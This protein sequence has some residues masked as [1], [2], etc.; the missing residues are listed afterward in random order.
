M[1][2]RPTTVAA[3]SRG[4]LAARREALQILL[5]V[6]RDRAY[7]DVLLGRRLDGFA[8]ADRRLITQLVLGTLAWRGRLDFELSRHAT[9]PLDRLAPEVL[10]A[11]RMGLFQIRIL[12]RIPGHAA[13]DTAVG[14]TRQLAGRRSAGLVNAVLRKA[15]RCPV[16]LPPRATDQIAYLAIAYSHPRWL[17]EKLIA[18]FGLPK[19][20]SLMS[21]NNEPAPN[22]LR[23]NLARGTA[24]DLVAL[25]V[26]DGMTIARR[27]R[28]PET[29]ILDSAPVLNGETWRGGL[30]QP[31][32]EASQIV[33]RLLAPCARAVVIDCAAAPGGKATH[34]AE[35]VGP[36]G[37]VLALDLNFPGLL[38]VR[39]SADR[40][41]HRNVLIARADASIALPVLA[42]SAGF[43]LLDAPCTG[44]GTLREHPE[45]RWRLREEDIDRM[46]TLQRSMLR[47]AATA[48]APGGALAYA[49][50]SIAPQEGPD[51]VRAFLAEHSDFTIDQKPAIAEQLVDLLDNNG[52]V[53]T[54][55]DVDRLDGFFAARMTRRM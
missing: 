29:V 12:S 22:V 32:A 40:L 16:E 25:L 2:H 50:C 7:A 44:L 10:G 9:Y 35:L 30:F 18:W 51:V 14:L 41:D 54:R 47:Q 21:A 39:S 8:A 17:V 53:Q 6:E 15:I 38:K 26:R 45:L 55:P 13:V 24:E 43:V 20:E 37:R 5:R 23:L 3:R 48:V 34:L 33:S 19:A 52:F 42:R 36:G 28:F 1:A 49:V 11:L 46:A 27:S 4:P 31:Q